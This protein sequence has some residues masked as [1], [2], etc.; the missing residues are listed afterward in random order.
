[1]YDGGL[2]FFPGKL[3]YSIWIIDLK[4]EILSELG[5]STYKP[6]IDFGNGPTCKLAT[7]VDSNSHPVAI[8]L[9]K[10]GLSKT[11]NNLI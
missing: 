10:S 7:A 9:S 1:M 5:L 2:G 3:S 6:P 8:Y 4:F 11:Y